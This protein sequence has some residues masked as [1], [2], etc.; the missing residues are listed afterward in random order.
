MLSLYRP[1]TVFKVLQTRNFSTFVFAHFMRVKVRAGKTIF[2]NFG[3]FPLNVFDN[4]TRL[5]NTQR[6]S[7]F[8]RRVFFF[9][10]S[11][12]YKSSRNDEFQTSTNGDALSNHI[13]LQT[14]TVLFNIGEKGAI[15]PGN[16]MLD[17]ISGGTMIRII[18]IDRFFL[19]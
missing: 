8:V 12:A 5:N 10:Y 2:F 18:C 17:L 4:Y 15:A 7:I 3:F 11:I 19:S 14:P 1:V 6:I 16:K 13:S 9:S